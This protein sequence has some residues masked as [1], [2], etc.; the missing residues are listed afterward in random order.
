MKNL[1]KFYL[2]I[3]FIFSAISFADDYADDAAEVDFYV[4]GILANDS[5]EQVNFLLC[6][7]EKTNFSTF[8]DKGFYKALVDEAK[9]ETASGADA[10]SESAS[11]TGGSA[12]GGG[13]GA[14]TANTVEEVEYTEGIYQNITSG[15]TNAPTIMI[16]E[17]AA[18]MI[19]ED[20]KT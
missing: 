17:K 4:P 13:G 9:C 15:N 18:D 7:M 16:A 5:M 14:G 20:S 3:L 6:F 19:I 2:S 11:A 8:V 12:A 10:A 1:I